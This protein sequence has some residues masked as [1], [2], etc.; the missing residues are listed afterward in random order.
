MGNK[1]FKHYIPYILGGLFGLFFRTV[2][3]AATGLSY[4]IDG[5]DIFNAA[6]MVFSVWCF[7][8]LMYAGNK[9]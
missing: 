1:S 7:Y 9:K 6:L 4:T 2:V 3:S 5:H 8:K